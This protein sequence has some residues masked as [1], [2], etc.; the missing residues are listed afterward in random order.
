MAALL[1]SAGCA[2]DKQN[3][4]PLAG[5]SEFGLSLAVSASPDVITPDGVSQATIQI[6]ALDAASQPVKGLALRAQTL[7]DGVATEIGVLSSK[8]ISTGTDG[9]ALLSY[10]APASATVPQTG[11][12][13]VTVMLTPVGSDYANTVPRSVQIR[14]TRGTPAAAFT[15]SPAAPK[16]AAIA[17]FDGSASRAADGHAIVLYSWDFGDGTPRVNGKVSE[18][19]V[20]FI[21]AVYTVRLTVYDD[22]GRSSVVA[23]NVTI[24]P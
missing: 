18:Q 24:L 23:Q 19:H 10:R 1:A 16:A 3:A 15:V 9:R 22:I 8:T 5:P 13:V 7:V 2:L 17:T 12:V 21:P 11:D 14:L 4:P 6:M 20:F